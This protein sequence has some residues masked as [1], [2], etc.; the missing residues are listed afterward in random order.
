MN[1]QTGRRAFLGGGLALPLLALPGCAT[2]G[3]LGDGF[4]LSDAVRRLLT[5]S[6]RRAFARLLE[7]GGFASEALVDGIGGPAASVLL[8]T[9]TVR[10]QVQRAFSGAA[11]V[12]AREAVPIVNDAIST[13]TFADAATIVRGGPQ[14]ATQVLRGAVERTVADRMVSALDR[15]LGGERSTVLGL[16][17]GA[18]TQAMMGL[19]A[20][21]AS[22]TTDVI[23][24]GIGQE[25]AAI[26]ANPQ[27]TGDPLLIGVFSLLR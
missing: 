15:G 13:L 26:R 14:A 19:V 1:M 5:L 4:G 18:G 24:R 3:E 6:S 20:G 17:R 27:N 9:P 16:L 7:P 8:R 23:F 12:A 22:R 11:Q 21:A 10:D 25:E 2:L